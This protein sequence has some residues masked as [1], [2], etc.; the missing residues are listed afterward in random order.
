MARKTN[1][2]PVDLKMLFLKCMAW[3]MVPFSEDEATYLLRSLGASWDKSSK[4]FKAAQVSGEIES[5]ISLP[6]N[7]KECKLS[8]SIHLQMLWELKDEPEEQIQ[9]FRS[10]L[11]HVDSDFYTLRDSMLH[12]ARTGEVNESVDYDQYKFRCHIDDLVTEMS[13]TDEWLD[14]FSQL[15][16]TYLTYIIGLEFYLNRD[17]QKKLD[18]D[19]LEKAY[20]KNELLSP[21]VKNYFDEVYSL[22]EYVLPD[23][24]DEIPRHVTMTSEGGFF[25]HAFYVQIHGDYAK[26]VSLYQKGLK[27]PAAKVF[28]IPSFYMM[29]YVIALVREGSEASRKKLLALHSK[30]KMQDDMGYASAWLILRI[31]MGIDFKDLISGIDKALYDQPLME[32]VL[33]AWVVKHYKLGS[34]DR[35]KLEKTAAEEHFIFLQKLDS[36]LPSYRKLEPWEEALAKLSALVEKD[37]GSSNKS[38]TTESHS[39][40]V[41]HINRHEQVI[42]RLQKSKDGINWSKGRNIALSTFK[43]NFVENMTLMDKRVAACVVCYNG[44][45][46]IGDIYELDDPEVFSIL[47]GYPYIFMDENPDIPIVIKKDEPQLTITKLVNGYLVISNLGKVKSSDIVVIKETDQLYRVIE[48]NAV[49]RSIMDVFREVSIFPEEAKSYLVSLLGKMAKSVT[50]HSDL[51]QKQEELKQVKGDSL[52]TV[53]L[54]PVG[55][56]I[57][58]ELFVKPFADQPIYCKAGEGAGCV[59]GTLKGK[60]VQATRNLK[61]EK[62]NFETI[63]DLMRQV[64]GDSKVVDKAYFEDYY[65]CLELIESLREQAKISRVEWPEGAKLKVKSVADF[66]KL[67]MSLKGVGYWFEIDGELVTDEGVRIKMAD[68][69]K[70]LRENKGRFIALGNEDFLALSKQFRQRLRELDTMLMEDKN[71]RISGFNASVLTDLEKQGVSLKKDG[72]FS[73]LQERIEQSGNVRFDVPRTLQAELRSYQRDGFQWLSQLAWWGAGACLADDM[74]LGKT[75]QAIAL[76]LSRAQQ[77]PSLVI[78]PA[79]VLLNWQNE[80]TRF[81]PSLNC[82]ILHD[83]RGDR[84]KMVQEAANY[85]ILLT[86]YGLLIQESEELAS[87]QWNVIVL[88]EAHTIKNKETKMSKAAMRLNGAFRLLMTG[89]P[90]QN[91]LGEI[92]NLFQFANPGLLGSFSHFNEHFIQPIEKA[93]DKQRQKQLKNILH[94]FMLRR[95]KAE[96]LDELPMKT[97]IIQH[98]ELSIEEMALYENIRLQAVANLE[99][100]SI[101]PIQTLAEITRLRQ[102][103]CHPALIDNRIELPSSKT[104]AFLELVEDLIGN[105]HRALVFSQFTTHLALVRK[106]LEARG[107]SYLYLDGSVNVNERENLVRKFQ[108]GEDPLFLISLKAGGTGLNLTAADYVI[109]LDPWWNPAVEDQA[110]DRAYRIG[111][112][113]PVTIYRLI[114]AQ[115]IEEKIIQLHQN[116][117]SLADALL[118]GSNMAH[119]LTKEEMLQLL[120][121]GF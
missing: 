39:R 91:H 33:I 92:W 118:D 99:E 23:R 58:A 84:S 66:S 46:S 78:A 83:N 30:K 40:I 111:Q 101:T 93:G 63:R 11:R 117:K 43:Q 71:L 72:A 7:S 26:A 108:Q 79:S 3:S 70:K 65:E 119:K 77:G 96:V 42:P 81:A 36:L 50:I 87:R 67:N 49:Q 95:T 35:S 94:P 98:I 64:I 75:V 74:G 90:I 25:A 8:P 45:Y 38:S 121:G 106:E 105:N 13:H 97:E 16:D 52:I 6:Y 110:S 54:Q 41:Y 18:A 62:E 12:W 17:H 112:K 22:Y 76:M 60:R 20:R 27:C 10:L 61:K 29:T 120:K 4:I 28:F 55:E 80:I 59:I 57:K 89:T 114:A 19:M 47:A 103:A 34:Y 21:I 68:L 73:E 15:P 102:A 116:K 37:G 88:D 109:H 51:L 44:G 113:R 5:Y 115:T 104:Q 85:D 53:Q 82:R 107:I 32:Q 14:F 9:I 69:L 56:G 100:G 2:K 31:A 48:M 1:E 86:T 24:I